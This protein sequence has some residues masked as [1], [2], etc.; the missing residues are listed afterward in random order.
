MIELF[1]DNNV[2]FAISNNK[3][4]CFSKRINDKKYGC[5]FLSEFDI[6]E[7]N[8]GEPYLFYDG[9]TKVYLQKDYEGDL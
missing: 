6:K 9:L 8:K 2:N 1:D 4:L 7:I 5:Y 3:E